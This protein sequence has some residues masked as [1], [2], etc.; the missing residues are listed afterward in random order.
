[1]RMSESISNLAIALSKFQGE[2]KNPANTAT[3]PHFKSKYA[4]LNEILNVVR[5]ILA[6][7]ELAVLQFP[8]GDGENII[9]TSILTHS[10][11][12]WVEACPLVLKADKATAQGA[13]SAI[14][15][16]RRYSI[17]ALLGISSEDDDDA[18]HAETQAT[19][20]TQKPSQAPPQ[21]ENKSNGQPNANNASPAQVKLIHTLR[22][23]ANVTEE[24]IKSKYEVGSMN[25]LTKR[26]AS[27][28]IEQLQQAAV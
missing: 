16:G 8:S 1:M 28:I 24:Y 13:G 19:T 17:S 9:I 23:K 11:G 6:K 22:N 5:P 15:Y 10:S 4:P 2:V 20:S 21:G 3:N 18:N 26:Q 14:T 12:E 27:E 25:D 7:Y